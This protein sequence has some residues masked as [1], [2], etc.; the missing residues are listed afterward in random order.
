MAN[1][2]EKV[3]VQRIHD[4]QEECKVKDSQIEALTNRLKNLESKELALIDKENFLQ[5]EQDLLNL[6]KEMKEEKQEIQNM[7]AELAY[8]IRETFGR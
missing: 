6:L 2:K 4:L 5:A 8:K 7:K 3:Y 1:E